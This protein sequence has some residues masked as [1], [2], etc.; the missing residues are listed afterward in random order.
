MNA[1]ARHPVFIGVTVEHTHNHF[2]VGL[3]LARLRTVFA[4]TGDIENRAE[5]ILQL[6]RF[7]DTPPGNAG[8]LRNRGRGG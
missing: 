3:F 5:L 2:G 1:R 4:I 8:D 7:A 6:K